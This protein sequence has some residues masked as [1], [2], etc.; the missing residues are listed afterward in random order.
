MP[1]GEDIAAGLVSDGTGRTVANHTLNEVISEGRHIS[2]RTVSLLLLLFLLLFFLVPLE[3]AT[4]EGL[5]LIRKI[6]GRVDC[7]SV[8][9]KLVHVLV[10]LIGLRA[11]Q[12]WIENRTFI[13]LVLVG[14]SKIGGR[15]SHAYTAEDRIIVNVN[16]I[17]DFD[18]DTLQLLAIAV[19]VGVGLRLVV[20]LPLR[21]GPH[22]A[23]HPTHIIQLE[24]P[25]HLLVHAHIPIA[26]LPSH[27]HAATLS[28]Q[29][30]FAAL[31]HSQISD[32]FP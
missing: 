12:T 28:S 24:P 2:L 32:V 6:E 29:H 25:L 17:L 20:G 26:L 1:A 21:A 4:L 9:H 3:D 14:K 7:Y 11:Y 10:D 23:V 19:V 13:L 8:L 15:W 18:V 16:T 22:T 31:S 30:Q 27:H 5:A